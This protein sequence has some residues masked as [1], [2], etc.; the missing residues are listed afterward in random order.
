MRNLGRRPERELRRCPMPLRDDAPRFNRHRGEALINHAESDY[1]MSLPH[2]L[3]DT[4]TRDF[5]PMNEIGA[6]RFVDQWSARLE[7]LLGIDYG[8]GWVRI[9]F[10]HGGRL[11]SPGR[12]GRPR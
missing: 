5:G 8:G 9:P 2:R 7:C 11:L 6:E 3:F 1:S 4:G 12:G 10:N